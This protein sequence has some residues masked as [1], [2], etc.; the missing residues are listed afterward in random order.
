MSWYIPA[1]VQFPVS[2]ESGRNGQ[3]KETFVAEPP[4]VSHQSWRTNTHIGCQE[5]VYTTQE[6]TRAEPCREWEMP[7]PAFD[8]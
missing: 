1:C 4:P 3:E 5:P 6:Q 8:G 2:D 7:R